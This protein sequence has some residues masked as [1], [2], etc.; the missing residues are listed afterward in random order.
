MGQEHSK[1]SP[2]SCGTLEGGGI[3]GAVEL[4]A[5]VQSSSDES[6]PSS[7]KR[8]LSDT[9]FIQGPCQ[10]SCSGTTTL[11]KKSKAKPP[12]EDVL[13]GRSSGEYNVNA[14]RRRQ[15][16][17][18]K[19]MP[20]PTEKHGDLHVNLALDSEEEAE[21]ERLRVLRRTAVRPR[22]RAL[23]DVEGT[24][25]PADQA[26]RFAQPLADRRGT[27]GQIER[28]LRRERSK[29]RLSSLMELERKMQARSGAWKEL[30]VEE[31]VGWLTR[32]PKGTG[33]AGGER[34]DRLRMYGRE[35]GRQR[36]R[37]GANNI[38]TSGT[39]MRDPAPGP[40]F[41]NSHKALSSTQVKT[42]KDAPSE[43]ECAATDGTAD[44]NVSGTANDLAGTDA[45]WNELRGLSAEVRE[46]EGKGLEGLLK[47]AEE[48]QRECAN[49]LARAE[50]REV[51]LL[52]E[53]T[54]LK[55]TARMEALVFVREFYQCGVN[56]GAK[57]D[58]MGNGE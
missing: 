5:T 13:G 58:R 23:S 12:S 53:M 24:G 38:G 28:N 20:E 33:E 40:A 30:E 19:R 54:A 16:L 50:A 1:S 25:F 34:G 42:R 29:V 14:L 9:G 39:I 31:R 15:K 6:R 49:K 2:F 41:T 17:T 7:K 11:C 52:G 36:T 57:I 37:V 3:S 32:R 18:E 26:E 8:K 46:S 45:L 55:R 21:E 4:K 43:G 48:K 22:A 10:P 51:R 47:E 35:H 27:E 44:H 56:D